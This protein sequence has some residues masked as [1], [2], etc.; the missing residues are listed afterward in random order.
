MTSEP[1]ALSELRS[2]IAAAV[3]ARLHHESPPK[4]AK[5][6]AAIHDAKIQ[7]NRLIDPGIMRP[8]TREAALEALKVQLDCCYCWFSGC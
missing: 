8:N 3:E 1:P 2:E 6:L 4:S 7:F 5:E